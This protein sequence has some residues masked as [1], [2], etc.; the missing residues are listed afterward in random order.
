MSFSKALDK[1]LKARG[2]VA[3]SDA[4]T[5]PKDQETYY[6]CNESNF[7]NTKLFS[8]ELVKE[9]NAEMAETE[10]LASGDFEVKLE[11]ATNP[12][13]FSLLSA[14]KEIAD[15]FDTEI[16]GVTGGMYSVGEGEKCFDYE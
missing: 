13:K 6:L 14:F 1:Y 16:A 2:I 11:H 12:Y 3:S 10:Q 5:E 15:P 9:L 7:N 8:E 4:I